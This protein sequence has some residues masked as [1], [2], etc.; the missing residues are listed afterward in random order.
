MMIIDRIEILD[1]KRRKLFADGEFLFA[2]YLGEIR[3]F[4][5]E[6]G[7]ELSEELYQKILREV[8][9]KRARE[10]AVYWLK[11]SARTE[12]ELRRKLRDGSYPSAAVEYVIE[13]LKRYGYIDDEEYARNFIEVHSR[14]KSCAELTAQLSRKGISRACVSRLMEENPINEEEQIR[15]ILEKRRFSPGEADQK[16][17]AK[18]ISYLMRKGFSY[19]TVRRVISENFVR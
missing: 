13:L 2:L 17:T 8:I 10:R 16:E 9:F 18:Q 6:E 15:R 3:Q 4:G 1:K 7:G 14:G 19:D 12:E 11:C 5:L